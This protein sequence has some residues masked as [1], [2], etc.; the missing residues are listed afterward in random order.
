MDSLDTLSEVLARFGTL[1]SAD[2]QL[3]I[4]NVLLP[5]LSHPRPAVRKRTT[6]TIGHL[7]AHISEQQFES[8]VKFLLE[9]FGQSQ[10]SSDR[11]RTLVQTTGVLRYVI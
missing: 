2:Q 9:K 11:L 7:V 4:Q 10:I 1:I 8:L 3:Q 6:V 5:L